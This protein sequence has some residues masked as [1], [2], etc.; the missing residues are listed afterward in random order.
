VAFDIHAYLVGDDLEILA[1]P[2]VGACCENDTCFPSGECLIILRVF[3][4]NNTG[5][6]MAKSFRFLLSHFE[7]LLPVDE[8]M[9]VVQ[10]LCV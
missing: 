3:I 2:V 6:D 9:L 4:L 8:D 7:H 10:R 5:D 1:V